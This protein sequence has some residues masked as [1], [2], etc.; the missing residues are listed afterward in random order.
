MTPNFLYPTLFVCVAM[1]CLAAWLI[2]SRVHRHYSPRQAE[3]TAQMPVAEVTDNEITDVDARYYTYSA[4][5]RE[6]SD[7]GSSAEAP[8]FP[9]APETPSVPEHRLCPRCGSEHVEKRNQ[10]RKA[11]STIGAVAGA[12]SGVAM[13]LSG[14]EVGATVGLIAGPIGAVFGGLAGAILAGLAASTAG[15]AAGAAMGELIDE[16]VLDNHRCV[17]CGHMFNASV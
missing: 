8:A 14:A 1:V 13:T 12:T 16:N 10:A 17:A 4:S 7:S 11:G 15:C 2:A 9:E 6:W 3:M 5:H